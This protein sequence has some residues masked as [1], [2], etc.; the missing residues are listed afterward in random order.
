MPSNDRVAYRSKR[1]KQAKRTWRDY[2]DAS[3]RPAP[4]PSSQASLHPDE[5]LI[6]RF[7]LGDAEAEAILDAW[8]PAGTLQNLIRVE[9][10]P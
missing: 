9:V 6:H 8:H 4:P 3:H 5:R 2:N 10:L 1:P 7:L